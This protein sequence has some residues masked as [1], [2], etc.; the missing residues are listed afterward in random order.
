MDILNQ[1][2]HLMNKEEV[3]HFKLFT[4]RT[5]VK[6][7]RKDLQLFDYVRKEGEEYDEGYIFERLYNGP[8]KNAFYRLKNRLLSDINKSLN[9][10]HLDDDDSMHIFHLLSLTR[11]FHQRNKYKVALHYIR[12][13]EK[14]AIKL[15]N[16]ELLDFIY[17]EM[18]KLSH[19]II[20]I[21]PEEYIERRKENHKKLMSLREVE[22]ILAAVI[23]RVKMTQNFSA[24]TEPLFD[25]LQAT[26]DEFTES[27]EIKGHP[28]LR[29]TIYQAVSRI[30]AGRQEFEA[31]E[32][33]LLK[34]YDEFTSEGIFSKS[35]HDL[36]LQ[37]I[38][39]TINALYN[40]GKL[41]ESLA[42]ADRLQTGMAEYQGL[43]QKK[44]LPY[45]YHSL[46]INYF[47]L[48]QK[49]SIDIIE[50][51]LKERYFKDD[52]YNEFVC[53]TNLAICY[54][55]TG[56]YKKA[57]K[58]IVQA[59]I[60]DGYTKVSPAFRMRLAITEITARLPVG[61]FEVVERQVGEVRRDYQELLEDPSNDVGLKLLDLLSALNHAIGMRIEKELRDRIALFLDSHS[62]STLENFSFLHYHDF[63]GNL[64]QWKEGSTRKS[65]IA[66]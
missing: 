33:Y 27:S 28:K 19:E 8:S 7:P 36:K 17:S 54:F 63:L 22:D 24:Q 52:P 64:I 32:A 45:Y 20:F 35:N 66:S 25:L 9:L 48:D 23:Y 43:L 11:Y 15:E 62:R 16:Y 55:D 59:K 42:W 10:Q 18:I 4:A 65:E 34:T 44:Y 46:I 12:K 56:Q 53:I 57:L 30:L 58:T 51:V 49:K 5:Q 60:H 41:R 6:E 1:I 61:D 38:V 40:T 21:N 2:I 29:T 50:E 3:R 26:I 47:K 14:K 13:A 31:L 37:M 39:Y